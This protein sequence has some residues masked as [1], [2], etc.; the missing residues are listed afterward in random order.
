M[1]LPLFS[2]CT[3][4][5]LRYVLI[6]FYPRAT[7]LFFSTRH[8]KRARANTHCCMRATSRSPA[9]RRARANRRPRGLT[10]PKGTEWPPSW[11]TAKQRTRKTGSRDRTPPYKPWHADPPHR[12]RGLTPPPGTRWPPVWAMAASP[13]HRRTGSRARAPP[14]KPWIGIRAA[15]LA[16]QP[17]QPVQGLQPIAVTGALA[18]AYVPAT[19]PPAN[20]PRIPSATPTFQSFA[21]KVGTPKGDAR[22]SVLATATPRPPA[23][24]SLAAP[25]LPT[26]PG[27][28]LAT[29]VAGT[30]GTRPDSSAPREA[31]L[32]GGL[33]STDPVRSAASPAALVGTPGAQTTSE[34][35]LSSP[36]PLELHNTPVPAT[37]TAPSSA[38]V[39][40]PP[41]A[42]P[43]GNPARLPTGSPVASTVVSPTGN[44]ARLPTGPPVAHQLPRR[45]VSAQTKFARQHLDPSKITPV[46]IRSLD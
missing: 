6:A 29:P 14:Y 39:A 2:T 37:A 35:R 8:W 10:P 7:T 26:S 25:L 31:S 23:P 30:V 34:R 15:E 45:K 1:G 27:A 28:H 22:T 16:L 20:G 41:S 21:E 33:P 38:L 9:S 19:L 11:A 5:P 42:P 18:A 24:S 36:V 40:G 44:P 13:R 3:A 32:P 12:P 46:P 17:A 4:C 43:T